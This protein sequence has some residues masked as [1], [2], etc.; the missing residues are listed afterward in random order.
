MDKDGLYSS[1]VLKLTRQAFVQYM[2]EHPKQ[3]NFVY[4]LQEGNE[5][6]IDQENR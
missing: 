3:R 2:Q 6:L 4:M 1:G 5:P